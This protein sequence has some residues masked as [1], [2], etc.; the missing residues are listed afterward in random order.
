M[1]IK[2]L[3][4]SKNKL[5]FV[6]EGV[7]PELVN[8][9]RRAATFKVPTLAIEDV[10]FTE[11]SSALYD[12]QLALRLGLLVLKTKT[13]KLVL[14]NECKCKGKGCKLCQAKFTLKEDGPK[15]V[16]ASDLKVENSEVV[17]PKT[18]L[19]WLDKDQKIDL[20]AGAV[21]GRGSEHAKWNTGLVYYHHFPEI[22]IKNKNAL[23][24]LVS[25]APFSHVF[26][27]KL[28]VKSRNYDMCVLC[29]EE[30]K[31]AIEVS[32]AKDK[33]V[34]YVESWGQL[35]P[36]AILVKAVEIVEAELGELK[37]K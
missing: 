27:S 19:V 31:G 33:F 21:L 13:D 37:L 11:N 29:G 8:S 10:Y 3:K 30:S 14:P 32:S 36:K 9:L 5:Q 16:Y 26:N 4:E 15:M 25:K 23:S 6:I 22:K 7:S 35:S 18:P 12:E 2:V 34:V 20:T 1:K 24:K 17:Y 28:E